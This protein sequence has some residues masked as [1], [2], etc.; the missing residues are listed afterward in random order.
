M[1]ARVNRRSFLALST[2][3][4]AALGIGVVS[5]STSSSVP[6][7]PLDVCEEQIAQWVST[8]PCHIRTKPGRAVA[9]REHQVTYERSALAEAYSQ[10]GDLFEKV[11]VR[12]G[13]WLEMTY[14]G[15]TASVKVMSV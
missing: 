4:T 6:F 15:H 10:V 12:D 9:Q 3:A 2:G 8:F 1:A 7:E 14:A 5:L 11:V 13:N